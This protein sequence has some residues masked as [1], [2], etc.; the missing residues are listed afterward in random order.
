M[1]TSEPLKPLKRSTSRINRASLLFGAFMGAAFF[2][3]QAGVM[4]IVLARDATCLANSGQLR[5][6][7]LA[8]EACLPE[9]QRLLLSGAALGIAGIFLRGVRW[10]GWLVSAGLY[11]LLGATTSSMK[12]RLGLAVFFGGYILM[13]AVAAVLA[14]IAQ[15]VV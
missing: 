13:T 5:I 11:A 6:G 14:Y 9:W 8:G 15:F 4:E 7:M 10:L 3:V 2:L 12:P 1:T